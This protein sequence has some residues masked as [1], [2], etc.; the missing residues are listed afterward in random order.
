VETFVA[1][2]LLIDNWRWADVPFYLRTGKRLAAR[3][4][5]IAIKLRRAPFVLFRDT[6]VDQLASNRLV[7]HIQ[8]D[9]GITLRLGAK[10]PGPILKIGAVDMNL[11]TKT[12][13]GTLPAPATNGCCMIA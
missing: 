11:I 13:L 2:K 12:I 1:L 7:L 4:T 3:D 8:P 10:I 9:E 6:P 5:E